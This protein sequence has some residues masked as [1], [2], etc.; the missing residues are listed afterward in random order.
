MISLYTLNST[1]CGID[2]SDSST[3]TWPAWWTYGPDWPKNGEIDIIENV[4]EATSDKSTLH[5]DSG[6]TFN[7]VPKNYTGT[8]GDLNC[9]GNSGCGITSNSNSSFGAAF[10]KKNG[11]L[12][13]MEWTSSGIRIWFWQEGTIPSNVIDNTP[14]SSQWGIPYAAWPFGSWCLSSHFAQHVVTFDLTFCG[15][16]A[17]AVFGSQCPKDGTCSEYVKMNPAAFGEAYW[18][19]HWMKVYQ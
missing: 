14:D 8:T 16:W 5:T 13:A 19:I 11:G 10:N 7:N 1:V 17:G 15:D 2:F 18:G 4:N 12:Y 6:C 9:E 3:G